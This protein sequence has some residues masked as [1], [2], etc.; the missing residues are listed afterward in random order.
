MAETNLQLLNGAWL[1]TLAADLVALPW[2]YAQAI[3]ATIE[4]SCRLWARVFLPS[5]FPQHPHE[6]EAQL[7]IPA[8][9]AAKLEQ[10]LFA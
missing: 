2:H 5:A 3:H 10:D 1:G 4:G 8:P 7:E 9:I 6:A